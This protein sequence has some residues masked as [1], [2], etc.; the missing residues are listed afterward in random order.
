MFKYLLEIRNRIIL[1]FFNW[2]FVFFVCYAKKEVL[3]FFILEP[4]IVNS[5]C[6]LIFTNVTDIVNNYFDLLNFVTNQLFFI[7]FFMQFLKFLSPGLYYFEYTFLYNIY[8]LAIV[9]WYYLI[10]IFNKSLL[11]GL[12]QFFLETENNKIIKF[13]FEAKLVEYTDFYKFFYYTFIV[14]LQLL[15]ILFIYLVFAALNKKVLKIFR[16]FF[17]VMFFL[18]FTVVTPPDIASQIILFAIFLCFF[19]AALFLNC[20]RKKLVR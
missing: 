12:L 17:Y 18:I 2:F 1:L 6:N 15:L 11:P 13:Y 8:I 5:N 10:S 7:Y 14:S 3:L 19:E 20:F 9:N 16:K 4:Y